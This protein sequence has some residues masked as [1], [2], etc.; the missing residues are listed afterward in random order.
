MNWHKF[1]DIATG[2]VTGASI[3]YTALPTVE[4]FDN[5]P[6]FKAFY[7]IFMVFVVKIA[8]INL[9]SMLRPQIQATSNKGGTSPTPASAS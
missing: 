5:Y 7:G 2:I 6:R 8:S 1:Y 9:R 4:S 3:L